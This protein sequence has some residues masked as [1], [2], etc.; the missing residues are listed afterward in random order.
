MKVRAACV[1]AAIGLAAPATAA[2]EWSVIAATGA[3][4]LEF[5]PTTLRTQGP[6]TMAWTRM[7]LTVPQFSEETGAKYQSQLQLHAIDCGASA[8]TVVGVVLYQGALGRGEVVER[9]TRPR[10]EW[11]PKP[12]PPGSLGEVTVRHACAEA[13]RR[14]ARAAGAGKTR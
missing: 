13:A 10:A 12:V 2:A 4:F 7:T 6:Y 5:D 8:S 3:F 11:Q 1:A 14:N 9:N